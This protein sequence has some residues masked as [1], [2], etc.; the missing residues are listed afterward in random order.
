MATKLLGRRGGHRPLRDDNGPQAGEANAIVSPGQPQAVFGP[1]TGDIMVHEHVEGSQWEPVIAS[2]T[3]GGYAVAWFQGGIGADKIYVRIFDNAGVAQT[4]EILVAS[5][6]GINGVV[7]YPGEDLFD[8]RLSI[9]ATDDGGMVL[10]WVDHDITLN[11]GSGPIY[12]GETKVFAQRVG[13]DGS[14]VGDQ[15]EVD[16]APTFPTGVVSMNPTVGAFQGGGFLVI[17][18]DTDGLY[19]RTYGADNVLGFQALLSTNQEDFRGSQSIARLAN[20]NLIAVWDAAYEASGETRPVLEARIITPNDPGG[21]FTI[22]GSS[23]GA[24]QEVAVAA[25]TSGGFVATWIANVGGQ[26]DVFAQTFTATGSPVG[27]VIR[28]NAYV[29]GGQFKPSVAGMPDGGFVISYESLDSAD[30]LSSGIY[31]QR[32]DAGGNALGGAFRVNSQIDDDQFQGYQENVQVLSNGSLVFGWM[33]IGEIGGQANDTYNTFMRIFSGDIPPAG[34]L[35]GTPETDF[36]AGTAGND[37]IDGRGGNDYLYGAGG[38]DDLD[39]GDGADIAD[40]RGQ[41]SD[42]RVTVSNGVYT[43]VDLRAGSPD[44]TDTL[45]NIEQLRFNDGTPVNI[46]DTV[47]PAPGGGG[48]EPIGGEIRVN[49]F[50]TGTQT[51][52]AITLLSNGT[53]VV[54]WTS[55]GQDGSGEGVYAQRFAADGTPAG[56]EFRV[57]TTTADDQRAPALTALSGGGFVITWETRVGGAN[58]YDIHAQRYDVAGTPQGG[59]FLVN[60]TTAS[61][62]GKSAVAAFSGGGYIVVWQ[63]IVGESP[64]IFARRFNA[65][66]S[67]AS[68]EFRVNSFTSDDQE[69]A[70]VAVLSG[71]GF[72]VAWESNGQDGNSEGVYGQLYTAAGAPVGVEFRAN[73]TTANVQ[74]MPSVTALEGGGFVIVWSGVAVR[75]QIYAADGTPVGGEIAIA[76]GFGGVSVTALAGGGFAVAWNELGST[77]AGDG[78]GFSVVARAFNAG[79]QA[80]GDAPSIINE[81]TAGDQQTGGH[82][83]LV[84]LA[85]GSVAVV[86]A[87]NGTG[88]TSGV[89]V[90]RYD[91]GGDIAGPGPIVGTPG[92][93]TL[94][95]TAGDDV[96]RGLGGNDT[97]DGLGGSDTAE[98]LGVRANYRVTVSN[99]VYTIDDQR[100][101]SPDGT[102]TLTNVEFL[103]FSDGE[104]VAIADA[105]APTTAPGLDPLTGAMLINATSEPSAIFPMTVALSGGG[106]A[107]VWL[108]DFA[109]ENNPA[110]LRGR[111]F[112]AAGQPVGDEFTVGDM[113]FL[114][115]EQV[116]SLAA[117]AGG[118]FAVTWMSPSDDILDQYQDLQV[119]IYDALG[120][121][122]GSQINAGSTG[123]FS[124]PVLVGTANGGFLLIRDPENGMDEFSTTGQFFNSSGT[125]IGSAF[126]VAANVGDHVSAAILTNGDIVMAWNEPP[127]IGGDRAFVRLF[128]PTGQP[129]GEAFVVDT[130]QPAGQ[131]VP[132]VAALAGGGFVMTWFHNN[133]DADI[134]ARIFD[135]AGNPVTASFTV[136][137]NTA[138]TQWYGYVEALDDGGFVVSWTGADGSSDGVFARVFDASG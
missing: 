91:L 19:G 13:A 23:P 119:R 16:Q 56:A 76:A 43:I 80:L 68:A 134:Y 77:G 117:L 111:A 18:N 94:T 102:D 54:A 36:L 82:G 3:G 1:L 88:D 132:S 92:V 50:T 66:G 60:E 51:N 15:I 22:S 63:S 44:G 35:T 27:T 78:A 21:I 122:V 17:Y 101:G 72:V 97:I 2:L 99:G 123:R 10:A 48:G 31:A 129:R 138:G 133:P 47:A 59:E 115:E 106:Y 67:P 42:Y 98:Y 96:I 7:T 87:G 125:A 69:E 40:Y 95:G 70:S 81:T 128:S 83:S 62:Q 65:D 57:A 73:T 26:F 100:E 28:V 130:V 93:D 58:S 8:M 112:D 109:I 85:D 25:L 120:A 20:G 121:P 64:E 135:A 124:T 105:V 71:G 14:L 114:S 84:Q 118:G 89:F 41:Q 37:V 33:G 126:P 86:W 75:G 113:D 137:E 127:Q 49:S 9:A 90:R 5:G 103:R 55:A 79:G 52:P 61:F 108:G 30:P 104:T 34:S 29:P 12:S 32:F 131:N 116:P 107:V 6:Q 38:N 4:G 24:P 39:G 136:N 45:R 110:T 11:T 53:F 46:Q 74:G